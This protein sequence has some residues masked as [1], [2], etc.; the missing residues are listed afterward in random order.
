MAEWKI[1]NQASAVVGD[2]TSST[3]ELAY[4][5]GPTKEWRIINVRVRVQ[6]GSSGGA[7][8][9]PVLSVADTAGTVRASYSGPTLA[10]LGVSDEKYFQFAMG[11]ENDSG[12]LAPDSTVWM[13]SI[14]EI[15]V[16]KDWSLTVALENAATNDSM[17]ASI[18]GWS[19]P[20]M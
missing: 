5:P 1:I 20:T 4:A 8:C 18:M 19:R 16:P 14:P 7:V 10:F 9:T 11:V 13:I 12:W 6:R 17:S 2:T 3:V 15:V